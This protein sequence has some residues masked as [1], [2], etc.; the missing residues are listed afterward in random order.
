[1]SRARGCAGGAG[2]LRDMDA[3]CNRF[4]GTDR[5]LLSSVLCKDRRGGGKQERMEIQRSGVRVGG[6]GGRE[7]GASENKQGETEMHS[8]SGDGICAPSVSA[9]MHGCTRVASCS[10]NA[11]KHLGT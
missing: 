11:P 9:G 1:M 4:F 3:I 8:K 6:R 2:D 10:I 5:S 7:K